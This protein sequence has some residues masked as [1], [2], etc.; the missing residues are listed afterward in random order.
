MSA[1]VAGLTCYFTRTLLICYKS[2]VT[3]PEF[4]RVV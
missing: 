3:L 4:C 1:I 2:E